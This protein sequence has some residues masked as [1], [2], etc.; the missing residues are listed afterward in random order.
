MAIGNQLCTDVDAAVGLFGGHGGFVKEVAGASCD[1]PV[2]DRGV[3]GKVMIHAHVDKE[4]FEAVLT[5]EHVHAAPAAAEVDHLLPRDFAG[6][7][8]HAFAFDT[9]VGTEKQMAG[10]PEHRVQALLDQPDLQGQLFEPPHG[11]FGLV[12]VVDFVL[13]RGAHGLV[14]R[15]N[16][17]CLH[18]CHLI[19]TGMP[20]TIR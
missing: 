13:Q 6:G 20:L 4:Q 19:L 18:G 1:F 16:A 14:G 12:Q 7:D 3:G 9:M 2:Q 17:E 5:A 15:G 8:A 10:M 11:T